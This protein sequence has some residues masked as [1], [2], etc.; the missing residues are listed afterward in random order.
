[1]VAKV[2]WSTRQTVVPPPCGHERVTHRSLHFMS[3]PTDPYLCPFP[4]PLFLKSLIFK[5]FFFKPLTNN[6]VI[7]QSPWICIYPSKAL[8]VLP[9]VLPIGRV[10]PQRCLSGPPLV[11]V[12]P[13]FG[14]HHW[15]SYSSVKLS[16]AFFF[17]CQLITSDPPLPWPVVN[18]GRDMGATVV[19]FLGLWATWSCSLL[20]PFALHMSDPTNTTSILW[21][22][23]AT[24]D[25]MRQT[26]YSSLWPVLATLSLS[27]SWS[28][29][30]W[31]IN[32]SLLQMA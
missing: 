1:M 25:F 17:L 7:C 31:K 28:T 26:K 24:N 9:K 16:L 30:F 18:K 14:L 32:H 8:G 3:M 13:I 20:M 15:L 22:V 6:Q 23:A 29:N 11:Q 19:D 2:N 12:Q 27:G 10:S 5:F 21:C 4:R